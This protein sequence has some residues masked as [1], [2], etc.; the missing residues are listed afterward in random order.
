MIIIIT[1]RSQSNQQRTCECGF[2][3]PKKC[4]NK[5]YDAKNEKKNGVQVKESTENTD[6]DKM[7]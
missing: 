2:C 1:N 7:K 5:N 4:C 3:L 6:I